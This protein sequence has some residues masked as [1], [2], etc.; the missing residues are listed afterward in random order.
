[1]RRASRSSA[2]TLIELLAVIAIILILLSLLVP[3]LNGARERANF[4]VC[5]ANLGQIGVAANVYASDEDDYPYCWDWLYSQGGSLTVGGYWIEWG[6][7]NAFPKGSI[8]PYLGEA[9]TDVVLCPTFAK[10]CG[11]NPGL[12][13]LVPQASYDMNEY[14]RGP[15][16]IGCWP[17]NPVGYYQAHR[18][19]IMRPAHEGI[20]CEEDPWRNDPYAGGTSW[21]NN[22]CFGTAD[23]DGKPQGP[24][25]TVRD[26]LGSFHLP[27]NGNLVEG[28][29]NVWCADG[30][31]EK[32]HPS[33]SKEFM[34]PTFVKIDKGFTP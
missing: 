10:V 30:H 28:F 4:A 16:N 2:F 7:T 22:F 15:K 3:A 9:R 21:M 26:A 12:P 13:D 20:F 17:N 25:G 31:V 34:T 29:G 23:Y 5:K 8:R 24:G 33:Q 11:N 27:P 19:L 18:S 32:A 14:Y 6:S 1:M